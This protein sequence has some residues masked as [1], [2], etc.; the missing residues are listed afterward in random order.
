MSRIGKKE[1]IIPKDVTVFLEN[2]KLTVKGTYGVLQ[3]DYFNNLQIL[4]NDNKILVLRNEDSKKSRAIHGLAR[5]L[6]QNMIL[7]VHQKFFQILV[8]EGI[9]YKF[10]VDKQSLILNMG[11]SHPIELNI[12]QNITVKVESTTKISISGIDK[13]KVGLFAS[14]IRKIRPPEPYKGKGI[15]YEN[16]IILR[17]AG[18]TGK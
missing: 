17:K 15:R 11:Y 9:G 2:N 12:P 18:K 14:E 16:E 8:V 3:L 4:I 1:I 10:H 5:A 6:I 13:Q 7:G